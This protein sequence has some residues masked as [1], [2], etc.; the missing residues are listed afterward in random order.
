LDA[1]FRAALAGCTWLAMRAT[2]PDFVARAAYL[3]DGVARM[4]ISPRFRRIGYLF[5][6]WI[7]GLQRQQPKLV[8]AAH[9][10]GARACVELQQHTS[11]MMFDGP[12]AC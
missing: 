9:R 8:G 10:L 12:T 6:R 7:G 3:S 4:G 2:L 5:W 1:S 11:N